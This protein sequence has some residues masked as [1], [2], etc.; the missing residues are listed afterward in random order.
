MKRSE[1]T[2]FVDNLAQDLKGATCIVLIDYTG[3]SVKMQQELKKKLKD[4]E[5]TMT[6]VKNTLF[7]LAGKNAKVPNETLTDKV[8][9]GPTALV[10]SEKDPIAPLQVLAKFAKENEIPNFKVGIVDGA[11]Q[12]KNS[13]TTLSRLPSKDVLVAQ[14]VGAIAAPMYG[15]VATLQ[16]NLQKLVYILKAKAENQ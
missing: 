3:L 1:K 13:L 4:C 7:K 16:G 15:I 10:I 6:V 12:D 2:F 14:T 9:S 8:L 11:F 5:A